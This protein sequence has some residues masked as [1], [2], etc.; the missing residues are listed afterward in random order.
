MA[1][2]QVVHSHSIF[3]LGERSILG[4]RSSNCNAR[5]LL[6]F[7]RVGIP[8]LSNGFS[9]AQSVIE[10]LSTFKGD[11]EY[12]FLLLLDSETDLEVEEKQLLWSHAVERG[13]TGVC[14]R[15]LR[16]GFPVDSLYVHC[17]YL[18]MVT[19]L[20]HACGASHRELALLLLSNGADPTSLDNHGRSCLLMASARPYTE[21]AGSIED[22][23]A[24]LESLLKTDAIQH[25]DT[26]QTE[27][28]SEVPDTTLSGRHGWP[29]AD[30]CQN[31]RAKAV[32]VLLEAGANP[33]LKT[34]S[35]WTALHAACRW[36]T[37]ETVEIAR[38]LVRYGADVNAISDLGW[39][40]LGCAASIGQFVELIEILVESGAQIEST[41]GDATSLQVAARHD[42]SGGEVVK[43]LARKGADV[44][45]IGG[46]FGSVL[47]ATLE[48]PCSFV[49]NDD[50]SIRW[51]KDPSP[52]VIK[53]LLE[54]LEHGLD[55]NLVPEGSQLPLEVA[56]Q[57]NLPLVVSF[58][59]GHGAKLPKFKDKAYQ[60]SSLDRSENLSL[61]RTVHQMSILSHLQP[62]HHEVFGI[63][64]DHGVPPD[65]DAIGFG[66]DSEMTV[67][68][69][70]CSSAGE[71]YLRTTTLLL[72]QG[73]DPNFRDM[74]GHLPIQR[75]A[76]AV[77]LGHL[78]KLVEYSATMQIDDDDEYCSLLHSLCKG[79]ARQTQRDPEAFLSCFRFLGERL[80][81]GSVWRQDGAGRNCL[82]YLAELSE[83]TC[84]VV[85]L[86]HTFSENKSPAVPIL[87][88]FFNLH[89]HPHP[90]ERVSDPSLEVF[91]AS[92]LN[93]QL[94]FH[95]AS[96]R[97]DLHFVSMLVQHIN[98]L[99]ERD[100]WDGAPKEDIV[101][102]LL[103]QP[104]KRGWSALHHA[105]SEGRAFTCKYIL[106]AS[107]ASTATTVTTLGESA[108][109][110][111]SKNHHYGISEYIANF[112]NGMAGDEDALSKAEG[113]LARIVQ[114]T[115]LLEFSEDQLLEAVRAEA[116]RYSLTRN[117]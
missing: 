77:S 94:A 37:P 38:L 79:Y 40:P 47:L 87:E 69:A 80:P 88:E 81:R 39:T 27:I 51:E 117:V 4:V 19:A 15:L 44:N 72:E 52:Q 13:Y 55:L 102:A 16:S 8:V 60:R 53:F 43:Y 115:V 65:A 29:L 50:R 76:Y 22:C 112:I 73:A 23:D 100:D 45:A 24:V 59:L 26:P 71:D 36:H 56:A 12:M 101:L 54:F 82:H 113:I 99:E 70:A 110:L 84:L 18:D 41:A 106:E 103:T 3:H 17:E 11:T 42:V 107:K 7:G 85:K 31:L 104:D 91:R 61:P 109:D 2:I 74:Q 96:Q 67:L 5:P 62:Y 49:L 34:E 105:A 111:A 116:E 75:A 68:G 1:C 64:L 90:L 66:G 48:R 46:K 10:A 35:G 86:D 92:D 58:L 32:C 25:I 33:N 21:H 89:G 108:Q 9:N 83:E 28:D 95:I 98:S 97:G 114:K 30:A 57:N 20:L 93:G 14:Q 6:V 63:L 78:Q